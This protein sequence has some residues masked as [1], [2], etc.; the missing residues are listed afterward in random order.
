ML[1][2]Y[3][4]TAHSPRSTTLKKM[5]DSFLEHIRQQHVPY[6]RNCKFCIQG[7]ARH[8][9]HR[10]VIAPQAWTLSVDTT[11]PF[12]LGIDEGTNKAKYLIV[13][14][15]TIPRI[16]V[17]KP[18]TDSPAAEVGH[19]KKAEPVE[20]L[21]VEDILDDEGWFGDSEG[22]GDP[23]LAPGGLNEL[24]EAQDA[25]DVRVAVD[26]EKWRKEAEQEY[27]PKVKMVEWMLAEPVTNKSKG[28]VLTAVGRMVARIHAEGFE[29]TRHH[30]DRGKEFHNTSMKAW[31]AKHKIHRTLAIPEEHQGNGR[32]EGAILRKKTKIRTLLQSAELGQE[33]W[34][35]AAR[36]R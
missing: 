17:E 35:L 20:E 4:A 33:E 30:S 7:G 15:L 32:A 5:D 23:K 10:R 34:P 21:P 28:E 14:V 8:K 26:Q 11:G 22:E 3:L 13:G 9:T 12:K 1:R 2:A 29:V 24:R 16:G 6:R 31:C 27:L 19:Y 18:D 25:W 36:I